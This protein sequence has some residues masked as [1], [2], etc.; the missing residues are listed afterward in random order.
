MGKTVIIK[1]IKYLN[2]YV[3]AYLGISFIIPFL[4]ASGF[5]LPENEDIFSWIQ[6]SG[7]LITIVSIFMYETTL[8]IDSLINPINAIGSNYIG[9]DQTRFNRKN[10]FLKF[11]SIVF[12]ICGT[13]IWGYGDLVLKSLTN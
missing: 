12:T 13:W 10:K 3:Y 11:I 8:K 9:D 5:L 6:R 4:A 2:K 7:A 1:E